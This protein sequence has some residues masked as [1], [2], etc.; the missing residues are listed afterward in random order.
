MKTPKKYEFEAKKKIKKII[1][2]KSTSEMQKQIG[3]SVLRTPRT[4]DSKIYQ[5]Y[6][7]CGIFIVALNIV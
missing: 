6:I 3:L 1:F 7:R 2:F 5:K 4:F